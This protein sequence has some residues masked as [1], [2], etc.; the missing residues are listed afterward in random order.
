MKKHTSNIYRELY[1]KLF[2]AAADAVEALERNEPHAAK[3]LLVTA[4]RNAEDQ[5]I[6][7]EDADQYT[8]AKC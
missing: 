4:L 3:K 7:I 8:N 5:V 6:S 2:G 1:F